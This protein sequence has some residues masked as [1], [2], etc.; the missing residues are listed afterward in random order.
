MSGKPR[1]TPVIT[2]FKKLNLRDERVEAL[3]TQ[4]LIYI[5]A[6]AKVV[7]TYHDHATYITQSKQLTMRH[8]RGE[9]PNLGTATH[10]HDALDAFFSNYMFAQGYASGADIQESESVPNDW[11]GRPLKRVTVS[12]VVCS[13]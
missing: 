2:G 7:H 13:R 12:K 6:T 8:H 10:L 3:I 11:P 4:H 9:T 5:R 1:S